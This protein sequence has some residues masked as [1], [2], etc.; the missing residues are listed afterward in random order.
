MDRVTNFQNGA[1]I[2]SDALSKLFRKVEML[3]ET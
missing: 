2:T 1:I 3:I